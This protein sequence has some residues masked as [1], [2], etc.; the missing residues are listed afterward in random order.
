MCKQ[1]YDDDLIFTHGSPAG[2]P[3]F[4]MFHGNLYNSLHP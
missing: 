4:V 2:R 1:I 3:S